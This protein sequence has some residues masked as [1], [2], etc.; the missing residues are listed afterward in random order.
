MESIRD[1]SVNSRYLP[2]VNAVS[3][4][5]VSCSCSGVRR[6]DNDVQILTRVAT[7][8]SDQDT[9][10]VVQVLHEVFPFLCH[11]LSQDTWTARHEDT[12]WLPAAVN[13]HTFKHWINAN[14]RQ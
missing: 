13:I 5:N 8:F 6:R 1:P 12:C 11:S 7:W 9:S 4:Y 2:A 3:C 14:Y 10:H